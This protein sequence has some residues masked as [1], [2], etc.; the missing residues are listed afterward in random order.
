M[1]VF[2]V[3]RRQI[4]LWGL[5]TIWRN[6][7]VVGYL[8]RGEYG[9]SLGCSIGMGY[10]HTPDGSTVTNDFLESGK[11]E[12]EVMGKQHNAKLYLKSPFDPVDERVQGYYRQEKCIEESVRN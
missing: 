11:Y 7:T 9:Y 3:D 12:I 5:E 8:R 2:Y 4:P 1:Y 6:D 10:V